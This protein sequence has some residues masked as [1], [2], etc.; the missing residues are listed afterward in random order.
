MAHIPSYISKA[1]P[2]Y[3]PNHKIAFTLPDEN[4]KKTANNGAVALVAGPESS[5]LF[6]TNNSQ[7]ST[8]PNSSN[9][10][11][12]ELLPPHHGILLPPTTPSKL[13]TRISKRISF[14]QKQNC[15]KR[16][17]H[18][19]IKYS[20]TQP[21]CPWAWSHSWYGSGNGRPIPPQRN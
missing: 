5:Q 19:S 9:V 20:K 7:N 8:K 10:C 3:R 6:L 17:P 11:S 14:P 18:P 2:P 16:T 12:I 1:K 4:P 21:Y 13:E 15:R